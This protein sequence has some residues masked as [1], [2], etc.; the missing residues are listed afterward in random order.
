MNAPIPL[1]IL[2][3]LLGL[4]TA[5]AAQSRAATTEPATQPSTRPDSFTGTLRGGVMA[6]GG[7][8]TGWMLQGDGATGE[9]DVDISGVEKAAKELDGKRVTI[10]GK[11]VEKNWP[12]RGKVNIL[13]A[14]R[15]VAAAKK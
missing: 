14:D 4:F 1:P 5:S 6:G 2:L 13:V 12:E 10:T 3:I 15:I 7:E 9:I 11:F 8:S